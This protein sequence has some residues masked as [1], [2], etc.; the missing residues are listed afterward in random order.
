MQVAVQASRNRLAE[1]MCASEKV[2]SC[3]VALPL[4]EV[5]LEEEIGETHRGGARQQF[6]EGSWEEKRQGREEHRSEEEEQ[7]AVMQGS[8]SFEVPMS[9]LP[10]RE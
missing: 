2:T 7:E 6:N 5:V 8:P 3:C 10:F 4:A 1:S 9:Q